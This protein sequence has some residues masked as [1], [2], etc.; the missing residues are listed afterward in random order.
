[1]RRLWLVLFAFLLSSF[2]P[3]AQAQGGFTTVTG[4]ITGATD[5]LV[6]SCGTISAQ[7]ITAGGAAPTL[8]G[9]GFSTSTSPVALG[10]PTTN[11]LPAG[12]FSIRLADSGVIVPSNTTWQFTVSMA[13]GIAPPGGTG[14][15]SF[16]YTTAINC[17]TNTPSTCT[18]NSPSISSQLS[19]LAPKLSNA[20]SGSASFPVTTAVAVNSGGSITVN[21]GGSIGAAGTGTI[22]A[23]NGVGGGA[24]PVMGIYLGS[25]CAV[26]NTGQCFYSP[27]NVQQNNL[28]NYTASSPTVTCETSIPAAAGGPISISLEFP[29]TGVSGSVNANVATYSYALPT[30]AGW[31]SG[32]TVTVSSFT[33]GDTYFNQ[34]CTLTA[35]SAHSVSCALIHVN[36]SSTTYGAIVNSSVGPFVAAD[37]TSAKRIFGYQICQAYNNIATN[38]NLPISTSAA[39]TISGF[40]N[41]TTVTMSGNSLSTVT[42]NTGCVIWGNTDDAGAA[43]AD[44]AAQTALS[45]PRILL[46]SSNYLFTTPHFFTPPLGCGVLGSGNLVFGNMYYAMGYELEG[47]GTGPTQLYLTP[48]FPETGSCTNGKSKI[49]CFVVTTEGRWSHLDINGGGNFNATNLTAGSNLMEIDGPAS[50]DNFT[51]LNFGSEM[52]GNGTSGTGLTSYGW[53]QIN[54]INLSACGPNALQTA[55]SSYLVATRLSVDNAL[56]R[57]AIIGTSAGTINDYYTQNPYQFAKYNFICSY[58]FF[59]GGVGMKGS[60]ISFLDSYGAKIKL[61]ETK[62]PMFGVGIGGGIGTGDVAYACRA[63]GCLLDA[64]DSYMDMSESGTSV[65]TGLIAINCPSACTTHL[66]NTI[67][68]GTTGG[69][70]YTDVAGS[71]LYDLGGNDMV[72]APGMTVNGSVIGEANSANKTIVTAAKLVLSAGWG[73]SAANTALSGGNAPIQFTITNTGAG[74]GASPTITYTFPTPYPVAP[75]SCTAVDIGGNNPLLNP[76]TTS[77]LTATGAVFTATGTPTVSDTEIMNI[78]CVTP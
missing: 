23:T 38:S 63:A 49:G 40:T 17:S 71:I 8:N 2:A 5:G 50:L 78:T 9:Q 54:Q 73:A 58:C 59:N 15:Q 42:G 4:T 74:Q 12:S 39:L 61:Y 37:A 44:T 46:S 25:S 33:G 77:S 35:T 72:Q 31:A 55:P 53:N 6:W 32:N 67:I 68:K 29:D 47:R 51:C 18:A 56:N 45:C 48:G 27:A 21:T 22:T 57:D 26:A 30:P 14:P 34:T 36:A 3:P 11:A 19:A 7:L 24:A 69:S 41:S 75:Y 13:P 66:E 76:F 10:C 52:S 62:F 1:M 64:Q 60:A 28:C 65:I 43:L 70:N 20:G 16:T